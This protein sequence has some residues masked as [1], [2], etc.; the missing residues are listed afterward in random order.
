MAE[1]SARTMRRSRS[2]S[3]CVEAAEGVR[4]RTAGASG[5]VTAAAMTIL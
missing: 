5:S 4:E 1:A 3:A 2:V